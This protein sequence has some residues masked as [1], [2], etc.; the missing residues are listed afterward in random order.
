V[1][2]GTR[3]YFSNPASNSTRSGKDLSINLS[4]IYLTRRSNLTLRRTVPSDITWEPKT[5][6]V[7]SGPLGGGYSQIVPGAIDVT[8]TTGG[9]LFEHNKGSAASIAFASF[10]L[11]F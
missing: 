7:L 1:T 9:I 10:P 11:S 8:N 2:I 3:M 4:R 6:R 5:L